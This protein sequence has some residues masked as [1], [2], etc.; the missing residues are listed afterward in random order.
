MK[1]N[2]IKSYAQEQNSCVSMQ[3]YNFHNY[4]MD[5]KIKSIQIVTIKLKLL[6]SPDFK[7]LN[8]NHEQKNNH[9]IYKSFNKD[10]DFK[11]ADGRE[12]MKPRKITKIYNFII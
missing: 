8:K 7:A 3:Y 6:K 2:Y 5:K 9:T 10:G 4:L 11:G 12:Q 1:Y